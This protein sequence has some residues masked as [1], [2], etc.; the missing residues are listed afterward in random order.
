VFQCRSGS[1]PSFFSQCGLGF[2]DFDIFLEIK[3]APCVHV[4]HA[5]LAMP[6]LAQLLTP[7]PLEPRLLF[8]V[9]LFVH[10]PALIA[11]ERSL[12]RVLPPLATPGTSRSRVTGGTGTRYSTSAV[13]ILQSEPSLYDTRI[14]SKPNAGC[15]CYAARRKNEVQIRKALW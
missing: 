2:S 1:G 11:A 3:Y 13:C 5:F 6:A 12:G 9:A 10:V 15:T 4:D 8:P 14:V 7:V